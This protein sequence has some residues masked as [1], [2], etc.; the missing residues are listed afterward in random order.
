MP[1]SRCFGPCRGS[2]LES[3]HLC[4][5][6]NPSLLQKM[7][8]TCSSHESNR[9]GWGFRDSRSQEGCLAHNAA[10]ST[11]ICKSN[12]LI[13]PLW[14]RPLK[15]KEQ[16][17]PE[18]LSAPSLGISLFHGTMNSDH[19]S[20]FVT[21]FVTEPSPPHDPNG[22]SRKWLPPV[23]KLMLESLKRSQHW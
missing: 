1:K 20:P 21:A 12:T 14:Q 18:W 6:T 19:A 15:W 22:L 8:P 17:T 10:R 16:W 9:E 2:Y 5:N 11:M 7:T 4:P 13:C 3:K 23:G